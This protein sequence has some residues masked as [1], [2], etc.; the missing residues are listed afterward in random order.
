VQH[1]TPHTVG[2]DGVGLP[3]PAGT[4]MSGNSFCVVVG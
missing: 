4:G 3:S 2:L 1:V